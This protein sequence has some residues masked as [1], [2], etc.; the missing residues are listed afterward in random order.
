MKAIIDNVRK[1]SEE[2]EDR[3]EFHE[4]SKPYLEKMAEPEFIHWMFEQNLNDPGYL[5]REWTTYE[6]P[7]LYI[8]ENDHFYIKYHV[9]PPVESKET[10]KAANI[11]H[12]HN[13][14]LLTSY[15]AQGPGYHTMHFDKHIEELGENKVR[16]KLTQ[17]FFHD[18]K[19]FSF[20]D[21]YE[22]HLVFN[23]DD[24]TT[25][26]VLWSPDKKHM[27]DGLR[28]NPLIKPFKK[29]LIKMIHMLGMARQIGVADKDVSQWYVLNGES[30]S[31]RE[32]DYFGM[33]KEKSGP[34][35]NDF[36]TQAVCLFVQRSGYNNKSFL[37]KMISQESTPVH[38]KKW[39]GY[40]LEEKSIPDVYGKEEINIPGGRMTM[41]DVRTVC[42]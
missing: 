5:Q 10:F 32:E 1:L 9:F 39:L 18:N 40:L 38:F 11:I 2:C 14:Y 17:D 24:L 23:M 8:F 36:Y 16:V 12:H 6:I 29:P 3:R 20:I 37:E 41:D 7:F 42:A 13:N 21:S 4:K 26:I 30:F 31:I 28:N 27:T 15:T 35:V 34:E 33:Y 19:E 22:P 25:T